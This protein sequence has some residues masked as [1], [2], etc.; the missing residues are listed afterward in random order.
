MQSSQ[1]LPAIVTQIR[2]D[3]NNK[4]RVGLTIS[5]DRQNYPVEAVFTSGLKIHLGD[6]IMLEHAKLGYESSA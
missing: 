3:R 4:L 5:Q 2:S 1:S 6:Q